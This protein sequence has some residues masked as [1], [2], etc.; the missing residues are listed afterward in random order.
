MTKK[1]KKFKIKKIFASI[2]NNILPSSNNPSI[3]NQQNISENKGSFILKESQFKCPKCSIPKYYKT[4]SSLNKH[5]RTFHG[6][7]WNV[8]TVNIDTQ[9]RVRI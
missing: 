7:K 3:T 1:Y 4:K 6:P 2:E 8:N 9:K 5:I